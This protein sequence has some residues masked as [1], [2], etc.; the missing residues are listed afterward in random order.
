MAKSQ[1]QLKIDATIDLADV[2]AKLRQ[3]QEKYKTLNMKATATTAKGGGVGVATGMGAV[4]TE[5]TK[6]TKATKSWGSALGDTF[7]KVAYFGAVTAGI[8]LATQG[9][10]SM[11]D[12]VRE[13]DAS[14]TE[15]KKVSNLSGEGLKAYAQQAGEVGLTVGRTASE[16]VDASTSFVKSGYSEQQA[17]QLAEVASKFQNVADSE[18]E[19]G[20][21]ANFIISQMKAFGIEATNASRVIDV[22]NEVSNKYAVS[23]T[24]LSTALS[25]TASAMAAGGNSYEET[26]GLIYGSIQIS[27]IDWN[28]LRV[29]TTKL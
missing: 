14:L 2:E 27:L 17:L 23:S 4:V 18:V 29:L 21:A 8:Q 9:M 13:L 1:Y 28:F 6:A 25:K 7:K 11:I 15:L 3:L 26:I 22:V 12:Q 20:D 24:D 16:M 19:A 10:R 5:T